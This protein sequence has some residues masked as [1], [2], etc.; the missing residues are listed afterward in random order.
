MSTVREI[1][2]ALP[3]LTLKELAHLRDVIEESLED[4]MEINVEVAAKIEQSK[5]E[6]A[7]GRSSTRQS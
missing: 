6:I 4:E 1:E 3:N 7:E 5:R 2:E